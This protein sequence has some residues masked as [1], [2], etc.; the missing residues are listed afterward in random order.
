MM[1]PVAAADAVWAAAK[2]VCGD[3]N[4]YH[5][6]HLSGCIGPLSSMSCEC[7]VTDLRWALRFYAKAIND[8]AIAL[9]DIQPPD[10]GGAT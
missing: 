10:A 2:K 8:M 9:G 4:Q 5:P 6:T 1:S 7:G 3:Q